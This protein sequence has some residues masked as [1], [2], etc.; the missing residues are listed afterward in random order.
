MQIK[1]EK[2]IPLPTDARGRKADKNSKTFKMKNV[3]LNMKV[4]DSFVISNKD[5]VRLSQLIREYKEI[6]DRK[7]TTRKEDA[8]NRRC[9]RTK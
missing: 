5:Y 9:W 6:K 1:I 4:N 7:F 8:S 3:L 2:N